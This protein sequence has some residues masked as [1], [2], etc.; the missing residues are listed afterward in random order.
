MDYSSCSFSLTWPEHWVFLTFDPPRTVSLNYWP[1]KPPSE[2]HWAKFISR[3]EKTERLIK[4]T[5]LRHTLPVGQGI[6][7]LLKTWNGECTSRRA[8]CVFPIHSREY[9]N[10][11]RNRELAIT[12]T[13]YT[14]SGGCT[15][16]FTFDRTARKC[17]L[18]GNGLRLDCHHVL[19]MCYFKIPGKNHA[20]FARRRYSDMLV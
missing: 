3:G 17:G 15:A 20:V 5:R 11:Y 19:D 10:V 13:V 18:F 4:V 9:R 12:T 6:F 1:T 2:T 8:E 7:F 16:L 14:A